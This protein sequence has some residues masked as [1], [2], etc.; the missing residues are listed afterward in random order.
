[1]AGLGA[2]ARVSHAGNTRGGS[3]GQVGLPSGL[4]A[5]PLADCRGG[6][7]F[8]RRVR[9][10]AGRTRAPAGVEENTHRKISCG[11]GRRAA[12]DEL[13]VQGALSELRMFLPEPMVQYLVQV[14]III[15]YSH[16]YSFKKKI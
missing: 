16:Y 5:A 4:P 11:A 9:P 13:S 10:R 6:L 3:N 7:V 12:Q 2:F 15:N 8:L 1:M 14:N